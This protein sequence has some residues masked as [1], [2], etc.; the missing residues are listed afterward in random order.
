MQKGR[1]KSSNSVTHRQRTTSPKLPTAR[2]VV[3]E[4]TDRGGGA[5]VE[6]LAL[7]VLP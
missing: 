1:Q 2:S 6:Q 4:I 3:A 7:D 5:S